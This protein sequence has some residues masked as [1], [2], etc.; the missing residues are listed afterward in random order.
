MRTTKP[1][2]AV[3]LLELPSPNRISN[4][5]VITSPRV[6]NSQI[7]AH[8]PSDLI[9]CGQ[10]PYEEY[11]NS[12]DSDSENGK[13]DTCLVPITQ[14]QARDDE[15]EDNSSPWCGVKKRLSGGVAKGLDKDGEEA[16]GE[17]RMSAKQGLAERTCFYKGSLTW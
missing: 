14:I 17:N 10:E 1:T 2:V 16:R 13:S 9:T 8:Q 11:P 4:K 12:A 3:L 5:R 15:D 6:Q 7:I